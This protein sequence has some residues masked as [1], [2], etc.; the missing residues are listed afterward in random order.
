MSAP[1]LRRLLLCLAL[2]LL[3]SVL[4]GAGSPAQVRLRFV[5]A[6][7]DAQERAALL[8][9]VQRFNAAHQHVQVEPVP[10]QWAGY[11]FHDALVRL[12]ALEDPSVDVY[13]IDLPWVPEL[14]HPGWL[15]PLDGYLSQAERE[16]VVPV[17][18]EGGAYQ[19]RSYA[20]PLSLK[21]NLLFYRRDLLEAYEL[22]PP[23]SLPEL[24]R[25]ARL[26]RRAEGLPAGLA[27]HHPYLYN[28]LLP[29]LW[30]S[31]GQILSPSG[32]LE[33][34]S[35]E[36]RAALAAMAG[37]VGAGAD[38]PVP[39]DRFL[40]TWKSPYN[41]PYLD[42]A[43]GR[44]AF[45]VS[46][47][48]R[49]GLLQA[50]DLA[51][52]VGVAAIPGLEPGA[53]SS[54]LGCYYLAVSRFSRH[55][56]EA[57][58]FLRFMTAADQQRRRLELA[59]EVPAHRE[60]LRDPTLLADYPG[61]HAMAEVLGAA[62]RRPP[63]PNERQVGG[64]LEETFHASMLGT[65][66]P[67][68][69]L[70][71]AAQ[72][73][74]QVRVTPAES[75]SP[76]GPVFPELAATGLEWTRPLQIALA[77]VLALSLPVGLL[78]WLRQRRGLDVLTTLRSK[79]L[80]F[81]SLTVVILAATSAGLAGS[82]AF[83]AQQQELSQQRAFFQERVQEQAATLAKN[84]GL[85]I[86]LLDEA[87]IE[88]GEQ[89]RQAA[90]AQLLMASQFSED[91]LFVELVDPD[92]QRVISDQDA[93]YLG[94]GAERPRPQPPADLAQRLQSGAVELYLHQLPDGEPHVEALVPL[95]RHGVRQG[96]LRM[97][98]SQ[99]RYR[100]S[101]AATE[102]RH[103]RTLGQIAW[104]SVLASSLLLLLG[105]LAFT[106]FSGRLS[107]PI[108][109]LTQSAERIRGG[110]LQL[111]VEPSSRDEV[112]TLAVTMAEMVQG[113]RDRDFIKD[114]FGRYL[115]RE[116]A[117]QLTEDPQALQLGGHEREVTI[118]MSDLRGFSGLSERL[119]PERMVELLNRYLGSMTAVILDHQ[120]MINE[121]IGD[122]ILVLFGA[123]R[124]GPDD[125]ARALRC[126]LAMHKALE[127]FNRDS[128][129]AG[130]PLLAMG[131]GVNTG[132]VVAGNIGSEQRVK[133]GVV[134]TA[135][136]L[137]GRLESLTVGSQ[138]L[139]SAE[140]VDASGLQVRG[141]G[142]LLAQVKGRTEALAYHDVRG[143]VGEPKLDLQGGDAHTVALEL[144]A[145][146]ARLAGKRVS[147]GEREAHTTRVG[148]EQLVLA[149]LD[150]LE[151]LD[152]LRL[153][154]E[155]PGGG[156][157]GHL[158]AKVLEVHGQ[159]AAATAVL[160]LTSVEPA[161]LAALRGLAGS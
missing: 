161:D 95:F 127:A 149:G 124:P 70:A 3:A 102:A 97:G 67:E 77:L 109:A 120:G 62:G 6:A 38:D 83:R 141:E 128:E 44:A 50:G 54:N 47:S 1:S 139:A 157:T 29:V 39:R 147:G 57:V 98:F 2:L 137:A 123:L 4:L 61:L 20:L 59:G 10:F 74:E 31:G 143:I 71:H 17:A 12:L 58:Q 119:G 100:A 7:V 51:G 148:A 150:G 84:L 5:F 60:L 26:L 28:D 114:A 121:F 79:L 144:P 34:D 81:G 116:L 73:L 69:A 122:A 145:R 152:N 110:D 132:R 63:V 113:L 49:W 88:R 101:L 37:M 112:G 8:D 68:E 159:G 35:P 135:V 65:S 43:A 129:S 14:A 40:H 76:A 90:L 104:S 126:A 158:Y 134:G 80:L 48:Q 56:D 66:S 91:L 75:A 125:A 136:N 106:W 15:L 33:I 93:L 16:A 140:T 160:A 115:T 87:V 108:V 78:L 130:L 64:I 36:N 92:G 72:A 24:E 89:Q 53:G 13:R 27:L 25:Q 52:K 86:S 9:G 18:L 99:S 156:W 131:I 32:E 133:Y 153:S 41:A 94:D 151:A 11:G 19:G 30:A 105:L 45:L 42:F 146:V 96:S 154:L 111:T 21:G 85:G 142:P 22:Q 103:Q 118:L 138:V 46:W 55:P 155:L 107:Q 23:T 82:I 117:E